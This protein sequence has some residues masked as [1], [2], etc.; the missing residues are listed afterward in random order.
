MFWYEIR[1]RI[2]RGPEEKKAGALKGLTYHLHGR[3]VS[4]VPWMEE[5]K[6]YGTTGY[7]AQ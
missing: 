6:G 7:G 5:K 4:S 3:I 2:G 1:D